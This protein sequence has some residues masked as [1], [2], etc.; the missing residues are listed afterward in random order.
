MRDHRWPNVGYENQKSQQ[1]ERLKLRRT[2][3]TRNDDECKIKEKENVCFLLPPSHVEIL[4]SETRKEEEETGE[5][6]CG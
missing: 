3:T 6:K 2:S 4:R 1:D 5:D